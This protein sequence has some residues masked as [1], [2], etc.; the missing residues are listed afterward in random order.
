LPDFVVNLLDPVVQKYRLSDALLFGCLC[1]GLKIQRD[2]YW[3]VIAGVSLATRPSIYTAIHES[4]RQL[5][6]KKE[7]IKSH[8]FVVRPPLALVIP[9]CP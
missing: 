1:A 5:R 8:A 4:L 9:E 7:V 6:R 2:P 3:S